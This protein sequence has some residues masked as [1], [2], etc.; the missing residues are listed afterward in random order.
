MRSKKLYN[1]VSVF[2]KKGKNNIYCKVFTFI[3]LRQKNPSKED[4]VLQ[5]LRQLLYPKR[6]MKMILQEIPYTWMLI[7]KFL[8]KVKNSNTE[9]ISN[10]VILGYTALRCYNLYHS[11]ISVNSVIR[12]WH[13]LVVTY[14]NGIYFQQK[15][16]CNFFQKIMLKL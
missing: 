8:L 16:K 1:L 2:F 5:L 12:R 4:L 15:V 13:N 3:F 6:N 7:R 10:N 14:Q 9:K 11:V